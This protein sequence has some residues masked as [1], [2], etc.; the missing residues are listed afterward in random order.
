MHFKWEHLR[1]IT[2]IRGEE[3]AEGRAFRFSSARAP[4][5]YVYI[6]FFL[7]NKHK[8]LNREY[9]IGFMG[10][11]RYRILFQCRLFE[12]NLSVNKYR[13][14]KY[15]KYRCPKLKKFRLAELHYIC[16]GRPTFRPIHFRPTSIRP[17]IFVQSISSNPNLTGLDGNALD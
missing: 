11:W 3:G 17:N 9:L 16:A 14:N 7:S 1:K 12:L 4:L 13:A 2:P 6:Y 15:P 10:H 8:Y 5:M